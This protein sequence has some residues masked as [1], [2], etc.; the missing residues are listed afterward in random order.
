MKRLPET[1]A[2]KFI[3]L[4]AA[5]HY[6]ADDHRLAG[7]E[8]H[9]MD[10]FSQVTDSIEARRKLQTLENSYCFPITAQCYC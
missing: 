2:T 1:V 8:A 6:V 4:F 10:D 5:M 9:Y 7:V 3:E